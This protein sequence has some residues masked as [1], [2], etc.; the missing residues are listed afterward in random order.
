MIEF[1]SN[2]KM[3]FP[4]LVLMH[5][6]GMNMKKSILAFILLGASILNCMDKPKLL[7]S[8]STEEPLACSIH[9]MI[10][11]GPTHMSKLI[12]MILNVYTNNILTLSIDQKKVIIYFCKRIISEGVGTDA[13]PLKFNERHF[14][15]QMQRHYLHSEPKK[16]VCRLI[17]TL[18]IDVANVPDLKPHGIHDDLKAVIKHILNLKGSEEILEWALKHQQPGIFKMCLEG[19]V[20]VSKIKLN[21]M[22]R[23]LLQE[24]NLN[25]FCKL[26]SKY[27]RLL[28]KLYPDNLYLYIKVLKKDKNLRRRIIENKPKLLY[29]I[30]LFAKNSELVTTMGW[31]FPK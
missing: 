18:S 12:Q 15:S 2:G 3:Y 25:Y 24:G 7:I 20:K 28:K 11:A 26:E 27:P 22:A 1:I 5:Y 16:R 13:H 17:N 4:L 23:F 29:K 9:N 21:V 19:N 31:S 8:K 14:L 6:K 30:F 10:S